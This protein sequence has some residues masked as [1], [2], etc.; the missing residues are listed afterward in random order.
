MKR[1]TRAL[2][3]AGGIL[4]AT[5]AAGLDTSDPFLCAV[6]QVNECLDG[7]GCE[8]V[9]PE[10]VNAP[11]FIWVDLKSLKQP[12]RNIVP[13]SWKHGTRPR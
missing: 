8:A 2:F 13:S 1:V 12:S 7:A 6:T 5:S 4:L 3:T 9:L 10:A 11:T